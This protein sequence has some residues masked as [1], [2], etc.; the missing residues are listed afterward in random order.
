MK[1]KFTDDDLIDEWSQGKSDRHIAKIFRCSPTSVHTRRCKLALVA[2]F[3]SFQGNRLGESELKRRYRTLLMQ[4]RPYTKAYLQRDDIRK[5]VSEDKAEWDR[6]HPEQ[7]RE[8]FRKWR[9]GHMEER[10]AYGRKHYQEHKEEIRKKKAEYARKYYHDHEDFRRR[11]IEAKKKWQ[12]E[13]REEHCLYQREYYYR[14]HAT[15]KGTDGPGEA[16]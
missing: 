14:K 8:T 6:A 2:N 9:L 15:R 11:K 3:T 13:H 16:Q 10:R 5:K 7:K 4:S 12:R 1:A